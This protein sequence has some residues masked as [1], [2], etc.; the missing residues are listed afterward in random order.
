[1]VV[2]VVI[3]LEALAFVI[4]RMTVGAVAR[5]VFAAPQIVAGRP[6]DVVQYDQIEI[7][8]V[9]VVKPGRA[10][11]PAAFVADSGLCRHV[12]EGSV[13][14]V[15]IENRALVAGHIKIGITVVVVVGDR[16][17]LAIVIFGCYAGLFRDIGKG[18]VAVVVVERG[19]HR[20]IGFVE[21]GRAG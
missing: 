11:R 8:V 14:V 21:F 16:D 15:V 18:S 20:M 7:A 17:A 19:A 10:G 3:E 13:A 4:P 2:V 12:G 5:A 9:V 1:A 6:V